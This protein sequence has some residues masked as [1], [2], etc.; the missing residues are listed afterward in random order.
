MIICI[1]AEW[2]HWSPWLQCFY[3]INF[4]HRCLYSAS[5][6]NCWAILAWFTASAASSWQLM[7]QNML[8]CSPGNVPYP[9]DF[10]KSAHTALAVKA[11]LLRRAYW[12]ANSHTKCSIISFS[13]GGP[14]NFVRTEPLFCWCFRVFR[15][16]LGCQILR[17]Y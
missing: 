5:A 1:A 2:A 7:P 6:S 13:W 8:I 11:C 12:G 10:A 4:V 17:G 16:F 14:L 15:T 9:H 3:F